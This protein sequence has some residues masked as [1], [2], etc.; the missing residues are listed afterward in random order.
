MCPKPLQSCP[1]LCD[2]MNHS[3]PGSSVHGILQARILEWVAISYSS[4]PHQGLN[5]CLLHISCIGRQILYHWHHLLICQK[6]EKCCRLLL[7][8]VNEDSLSVLCR[9]TPYLEG[10]DEE[11]EGVRWQP[12]QEGETKCWSYCDSVYVCVCVCERERERERER[13]MGGG[14]M[15]GGREGRGG[16]KRGTGVKVRRWCWCLT[17]LFGTFGFTERQESFLRLSWRKSLRWAFST[18]AGPALQT[19]V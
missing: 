17:T 12:G 15:E 8:W 18:E 13:E 2:P 19:L 10:A 9:I 11:R 1:T 6:Q 7:Y 14:L 16:R 4:L 5:S 3:P